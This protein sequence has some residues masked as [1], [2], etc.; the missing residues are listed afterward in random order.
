MSGWDQVWLPSRCPW[1]AIA[2][3]VAGRTFSLIPMSKKVARTCFSARIRRIASVLRPG[4]SSNVSATVR[5]VPGAVHRTPSGAGGQPTARVDP[6]AGGATVA[7]SAASTSDRGGCPGG[8]GAAWAAGPVVASVRTAVR[9]S[10]TRPDRWAR[11][12]VFICAAP[13][14]G[15]D[16]REPPGPVRRAPAGAVRQPG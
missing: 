8:A 11:R 4:P 15:V 16:G 3:T 5:P 12:L 7:G 1:A 2:R 14:V 10:S 13:S 6:V 9:T